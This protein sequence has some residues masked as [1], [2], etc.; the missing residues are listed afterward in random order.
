MRYLF[1]TILFFFLTG[2]IYAQVPPA[3]NYQAVARNNS[4]VALANQTMKVRLSVIQASNT[5]YSETRTVTTNL[6]GLFNVQIGSVGATNVVGSIDGIDWLNSPAGWLSL[7]V[8]LDLANNNVFTDMGTQALTSTP[9]SLA[10]NTALEP[11]NIAGRPIN[12]TQAPKIGSKLM[13]DGTEWIPQKDTVISR[14]SSIL[15]IQANPVGTTPPWVFVGTNGTANVT[16]SGTETIIANFVASLGNP[17]ANYVTISASVCYENLSGGG[18]QS[19]FSNTIVDGS[20][21]PNPAKTVFPAVGAIKLAA[22]TYTIGMCIK[23]KSTSV[24]IGPND[25]VNGTIEIRN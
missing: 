2:V 7:K 16:V 24:N 20:V 10:A 12:Q 18:I 1:S 22:G 21:L 14:A 13:W 17:S 5:L 6:L 9:F 4:G 3:F 23:N 19:F 15:V 11:V 25:Y 8:E